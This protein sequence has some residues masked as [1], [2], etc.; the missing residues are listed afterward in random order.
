MTLPLFHAQEPKPEDST[1]FAKEE[2]SLTRELTPDSSEIATASLH[3]QQP[4]VGCTNVSIPEEIHKVTTDEDA[5]DAGPSAH[6]IKNI[7]SPEIQ[8]LQDVLRE[9][10]NSINSRGASR[11]HRR[12]TVHDHQ[13]CNL[14]RRSPS[15]L[16]CSTQLKR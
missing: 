15:L 11:P 16:T 2:E 5:M 7:N 9:I 14:S 3:Q 10:G 8:D 1:G 6:S 13:E 4:A 12:T